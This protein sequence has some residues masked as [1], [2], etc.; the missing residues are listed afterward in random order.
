MNSLFM[1][2]IYSLLLLFLAFQVNAQ[3]SKY[4]F[5]FQTGF[6]KTMHNSSGRTHG[7]NSFFFIPT[8]YS[9]EHLRTIDFGNSKSNPKDDFTFNTVMFSGFVRKNYENFYLSSGL[10]FQQFRLSHDIKLA[11][12]VKSENNWKINQLFNNFEIPLHIGHRLE[13][14]KY[15]R[16]YA[17]VIGTFSHVKSSIRE[18]FI[19]NLDK[20]LLNELNED[21]QILNNAMEDSFRPFF[22][23]GSAGIGF[24]YKFVSIDYQIDRSLSLSKSVP[25]R[26][27][28]L[29]SDLARTRKILWV[30][31]KFPL[32]TSKD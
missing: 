29:Y 30:G 23:A 9:G 7:D 21:F 26:Q 11:P 31:V 1:K 16:V 22:L 3:E 14:F 18:T 15:I 17:G 4:E 27:G 32:N 8:S 20:N 10:N 6:W 2:K 5:G 28:E 13:F 12:M 19:Q 24:D 25:I